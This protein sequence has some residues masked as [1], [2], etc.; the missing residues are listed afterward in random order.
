MRW[1]T[2]FV[3]VIAVV[4]ALGCGDQESVSDSTIINALNLK[5]GDEG[6][7]YAING[8]PFCEVDQ[9]LLNDS[10][11]VDEAKQDNKLKGS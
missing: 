2:G 7:V 11:E 4:A 1:L 3:S 5:P 10:G 9:D 8:D 6:P